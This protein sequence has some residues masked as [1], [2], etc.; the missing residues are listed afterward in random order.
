MRSP[1][2]RHPGLRH[3]AGRRC[4]FDI[5]NLL[6]FFDFPGLDLGPYEEV[7]GGVHHVAISDEPQRW[8]HLG[9]KLIDAGGAQ[10]AQRGFAVLPRPRRRTPRAHRQPARRD[11][12]SEG[13]LTGSSIPIRQIPCRCGLAVADRGLTVQR[14]DIKAVGALAAMHRESSR[15]WCVT[16]TRVSQAASLPR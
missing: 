2:R 6:A 13:A 3:G 8:H 14:R 16:C 12:R 11:V 7:F 5:G 10:R 4:F 1:A 9:T 15:R